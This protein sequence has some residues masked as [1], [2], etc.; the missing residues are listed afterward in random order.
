LP[1]EPA[2]SVPGAAFTAAMSS[3]KVFH[4]LPAPT[5]M[6]FGVFTSRLV[7]AKALRVS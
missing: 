2:L 4:G 5:A 7:G 6:T 3:A 1:A